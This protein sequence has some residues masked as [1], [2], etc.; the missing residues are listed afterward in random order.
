MIFALVSTTGHPL[1]IVHSALT[2]LI[3][4]DYCANIFSPYYFRDGNHIL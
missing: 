1:P 4:W 3:S 2:V